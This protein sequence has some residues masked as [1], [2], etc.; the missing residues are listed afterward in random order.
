MAAEPRTYTPIGQGDVVRFDKHDWLVTR[1]LV[2]DATA[3]PPQVDLMI[4]RDAYRPDPKHP[5]KL[6]KVPI[7]KRVSELRV[8][9]VAHQPGLFGC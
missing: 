4:G 3:N 7:S 5:E 2:V 9:L 1:R 6:K 8:R